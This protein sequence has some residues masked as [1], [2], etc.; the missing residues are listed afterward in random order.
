MK[1]NNAKLES[2]IGKAVIRACEDGKSAEVK[3]D[4]KTGEYKVMGVNKK[5]QRRYPLLNRKLAKDQSGSK[6]YG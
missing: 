1:N 2:E 5:S 4:P 6:T 3:R